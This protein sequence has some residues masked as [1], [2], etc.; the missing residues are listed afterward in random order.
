MRQEIGIF[1][2]ALSEAISGTEYTQEF[3]ISQTL[4]LIVRNPD[5]D[6]VDIRYYKTTASYTGYIKKGLRIVKASAQTL[7]EALEKLV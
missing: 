7:K 5:P 2:E 6:T 1:V 4:K 3:P